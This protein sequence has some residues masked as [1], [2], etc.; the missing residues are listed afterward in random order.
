LCVRE[1]VDVFECVR[2]GGAYHINPH[3]INYIL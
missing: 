2:G 1:Y 3:Q